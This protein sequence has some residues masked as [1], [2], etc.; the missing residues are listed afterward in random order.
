MKKKSQQQH[1]EE[2]EQKENS[3]KQLE[4]KVNHDISAFNT[5]T[6]VPL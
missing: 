3:R 5:V 6:V 2:L 4:R 1:E